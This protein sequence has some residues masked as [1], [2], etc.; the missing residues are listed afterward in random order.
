M[1]NLIRLLAAQVSQQLNITQLSSDIGVSVS[2][3]K[4]WISVLE[5]SYIIFLLPPFYNNY[6]KRITKR[7]KLYFYDPGLV[8]YLTRMTTEELFHEGP[9]T[10][11]LF[12]NYV[13][14]EVKK[15]LSHSNSHA[16]FYFLRTEHGVEVDLIIDHVDH[17][18]WIEIKHNSTFKPSMVKTILTFLQP[19][20]QGILIYSGATQTYNAQVERIHY[21]DFLENV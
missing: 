16:D 17:K 6:G 15:K 12:E 10:G 20:D 8:A 18:Q 5:A 3:I 11:A 13:I 2:T 7:S 1:Y 19:G 21:Q 14:S 9:M 4:R